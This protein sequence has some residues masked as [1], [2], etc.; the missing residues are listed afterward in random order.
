MFAHQVFGGCYFGLS[1][2]GIT[3]RFARLS[4][5]ASIAAKQND[6]GAEARQTHQPLPAC[7]VHWPYLRLRSFKQNTTAYAAFNDFQSLILLKA[8]RKLNTSRLNIF[9]D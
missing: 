2:F 9:G 7:C 5:F 1:I 4:F 8:G 3:A 6:S